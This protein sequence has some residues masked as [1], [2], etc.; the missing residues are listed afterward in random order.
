MRAIREAD[1]MTQ[2]QLAE[3]IGATQKE[4]SRYEQGL[5]FPRPERLE[6][7]AAALVVPIGAFFEDPPEQ[8][9]SNPVAAKIDKLVRRHARDERMLNKI[10]RIVKILI[11]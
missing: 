8:H 11:E 7:I 4:V 6:L 2:E 3:R 10:H 9:H 5:S 1:G